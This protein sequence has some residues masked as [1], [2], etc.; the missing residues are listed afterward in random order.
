VNTLEVLRLATLVLLMVGMAPGMSHAGFTSIVAFGD[1]LS[2]TGNVYAATSGATPASP[3]YYQGHY[4]NGQNWLERYAAGIGLAAPTASLLGGSDY[5]FGGA[6]TGQTGNSVQG[7]PNIGTQISTYLAS[8][9]PSPSQLFTIWGGAND[10]LNANVIDPT[11]PV[12][13]LAAEIT[14]LATAGAKSF[15]VLDLP[16][17]GNVPATAALPQAQRD[18]LN[19]LTL[20]FNSLLFTKVDQLATSLKVSIAKADINALFVDAQANPAKYGFTNV[21]QSSLGNSNLSGAGYLFWDSVHPTTQADIYIAATAVS[22]VPEP[23]SV[24]LLVI[25]GILALP[26]VRALRRRAA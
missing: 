1:S 3:P 12:N 14:T 4:S 24:G 15:L 19:A 22:A 17:L 2:D 10:F 21:T 9:T 20:A 13:N 18:A 23:S 7:T 26:G 16:E 6:E 25:G 8:H 5:A 11:I